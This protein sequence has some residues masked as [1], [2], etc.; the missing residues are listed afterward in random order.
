MQTPPMQVV[1]IVSSLENQAAG[2]TYCVTRLSQSLAALGL[3]VDL[4]TTDSFM[5]PRDFN[6]RIRTFGVDFACL[7]VVRS[8]RF[9]HAL[10][11]ELALYANKGAILHNNGLWVMPNVYPS[12]S[13]KRHGVPLIFSPHGMLGGAALQFSSLKKTVFLAL[14]QRRALAAVDCFHATSWQEFE[15]IRAF[16]LDAPVAVIPNGID[17][18]ALT[19]PSSTR[20][21][22]ERTALYLGRVHPKKGLDRLLHAWARLEKKFPDWRLRIVGP[23]ELGHGAELDGLAAS[24]GLCRVIREDGLYGDAKEAAYREADIFV[25]PTLNENFGMV[26]AEALVNG[27][28]VISTK[29]APW[30][31]LVENGC[32]WWIDHGVDPLVA[33]LDDAMAMPRA[34]LKL[35][36]AKGRSWMTRD[37]SWDRVAAD[38]IQVYRW[39]AGLDGK[40]GFLVDER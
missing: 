33:T 16:G 30:K 7:P 24:F 14:A 11:A 6:F 12:W 9:S 8:L 19:E 21:G 31:G 32:G 38:M 2:T 25:L 34:A 18:P 20:V 37:F 28:P 5:E 4:V 13:A 17:L 10:C 35:M 36:G 1:Q 22:P 39:C 26:V 29:G 27:T 3:S 23:S 40:P 15:E